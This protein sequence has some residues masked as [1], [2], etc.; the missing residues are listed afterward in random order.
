MR[1]KRQAL[2]AQHL[3]RYIYTCMYTHIM[4][5]YI[6]FFIVM[7]NAKNVH[8]GHRHLVMGKYSFLVTEVKKKE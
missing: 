6:I 7:V 3:Y 2:K 8:M 5:R 1:L 4:S